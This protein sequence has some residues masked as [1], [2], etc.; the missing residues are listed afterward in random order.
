MSPSELL[1]QFRTEVD[2]L[3]LPG[4]GDDSDTLWKDTEIYGYMDEGQKEF[5]RL[6]DFL[7]DVIDVG[8]TAA[9][10]YV[11]FDPNIA[12]VRR[13]RL[14]TAGTIITPT[15]LNQIESLV[16]SD[17]YYNS[18]GIQQWEDLK[19]PPKYLITDAKLYSARLVPEPLVI[20]TLD[21]H[22]FRKPE[23][24]ADGDSSFE[25]EEIQHLRTILMY[26]KYLAYNKQDAETVDDQRSEGALE[27]FTH[28]V[29]EYKFE[30]Q[31]TR[32]R[33]G[34]GIRYGGL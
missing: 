28:F 29:S 34:G 27:K 31:R 4:N 17:D 26:M 7:P 9:E 32:R 23:D 6:T 16:I 13:A 33:S 25:V 5:V 10:P 2:D 15:T 1:S 18:E 20:D 11:D 3:E 14:R 30:L 8:V 22:I 21:L 12:K 24:I 19:G